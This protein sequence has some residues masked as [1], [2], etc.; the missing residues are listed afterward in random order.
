MRTKSLSRL[1]LDTAFMGFMALGA[2]VFFGATV[3]FVNDRVERLKDEILRDVV[4]LRGEHL[5]VDI[6]HH[7]ED[8]W[9]DLTDLATLLPFSDRAT[10]RAHLTREVATG[11]HLVWAAYVSAQGDVVVASRQQREHEN[12]GAEDWFLR[13]RTGLAIGYST[14]AQG[15][16]LLI[17]TVPVARTGNLPGGYL[18][19][20]FT[21]SYFEAELASIASSM[22]IEVVVF[23][24]RGRPVLQSFDFDPADAD[25]VSSRNAL[26]GQQTVTLET[27]SGM[28]RRYAASVAEFPSSAMPP[29]GW[30]MVVL[31]VPDHFIQATERLRWGLLQILAGVAGVLLVMSVAFIRIFLVPMHRMILNANE[32]ADGAEIIPMEHHRTAELSLLSSALARLQ[33]R[34]LRAEDRVAQLEEERARGVSGD[35]S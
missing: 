33:G 18:T 29:L 27:W 12:V 19:F 7:L 31:T 10:Y 1:G 6:I 21:P 2:L 9:I 26:A 4:G 5:A 13:A 22:A 34:M 20:H 17:M 11:D 30:R 23:D 28:G 24:D 35:R 15:A 16:D 8:H 14:D 3:F 32:I 25:Q